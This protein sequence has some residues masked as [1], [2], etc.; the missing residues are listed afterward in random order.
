MLARLSRGIH[1]SNGEENGMNY[2]SSRDSNPVYN[3]FPSYGDGEQPNNDLVTDTGNGVQNQMPEPVPN[4]TG[5]VATAEQEITNGKG[6]GEEEEGEEKSTAGD[7]KV[8]I[9]GNESGDSGVSGNKPS[10]PGTG[11]GSGSGTQNP[12][13]V[14]G[15]VGTISQSQSALGKSEPMLIMSL[16]IPM[17]NDMISSAITGGIP[18]T[19]VPGASGGG[20]SGSG[21]SGSGSSGGGNVVG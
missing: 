9:V 2:S 6:S 4:V 10:K 11:G 3:D 12:N 14:Q 17:K 7:S 5:P 20:G 13:E 1:T 16:L 18:E 21:G 8:P 19:D 15:M